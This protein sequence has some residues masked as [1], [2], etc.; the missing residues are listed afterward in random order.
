M[1]E[2]DYRPQKTTRHKRIESNQL[3]VGT[4]KNIDRREFRRQRTLIVS[5]SYQLQRNLETGI[6]FSKSG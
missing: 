1:T 2:T 5:C 4:G 3:I 6:E